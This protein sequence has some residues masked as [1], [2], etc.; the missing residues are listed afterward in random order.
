MT[1]AFAESSL[2]PSSMEL[3]PIL[4]VVIPR[5]RDADNRFVV[6]TNHSGE[7]IGIGFDGSYGSPSSTNL[8]ANI[9]EIRFGKTFKIGSHSKAF[10]NIEGQNFSAEGG[11]LKLASPDNR[12]SSWVRIF[13]DHGKWTVMK[14]RWSGSEW[15]DENLINTAKIEVSGWMHPA[16]S[17]IVMSN[18]D[19]SNAR[20]DYLKSRG[21]YSTYH[22]RPDVG[23]S[24]SAK[25]DATTEPTSAPALPSH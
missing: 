8:R 19:Q 11:V 25:V 6:I 23:N 7:L 13:N 16:V 9:E 2:D 17:Q 15:L 18:Q 20:W 3:H 5:D 12:L 24:S 21:H 10:M 22:S 14:V 4:E 1:T